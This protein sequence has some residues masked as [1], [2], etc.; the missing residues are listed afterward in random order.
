MN[1]NLLMLSGLKE[2]LF[3]IYQGSPYTVVRVSGSVN[4]IYLGH[5]F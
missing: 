3:S 2:L 1:N 4:A 5:I